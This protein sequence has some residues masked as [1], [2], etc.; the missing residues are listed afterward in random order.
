MVEDMRDMSAREATRRSLEGT[1]LEIFTLEEP[2]LGTYYAHKVWEVQYDEWW[3]TKY[4]GL[5]P[6]YWRQL[7]IEGDNLSIIWDYLEHYKP[8]SDVQMEAVLTYRHSILLD[9]V[10]RCRRLS[11]EQLALVLAHP[12]VRRD[13]LGINKSEP[14]WDWYLPKIYLESQRNKGFKKDEIDRAKLIAR[15][16]TASITKSS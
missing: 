2:E 6:E 8:I 14:N 1:S 4:M 11:V 3:Q 16:L 15:Q 13:T 10:V 12:K 7:M 9:T 5:L